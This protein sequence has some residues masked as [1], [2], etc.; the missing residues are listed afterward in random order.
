MLSR[1]MPGVIVAAA[2]ISERYGSEAAAAATLLAT[3][4]L[5]VAAQR[6]LAGDSGRRLARALGADDLSPRA[7]TRLRFLRRLIVAGIVVV[8]VALAAAQFTE[9]NRVANT[10]LASSAIAAAIVGFAARQ[11]LANAIA[12]LLLAVTQ[13][14]RIGDLV[15]FEEETGTVEELTLTSTWLRTS[16]DARIVI[17]NE[18]LA[19]GILRNDSIRSA[20]VAPEVSV[21]LAAEAD[22]ARALQLLSA[23]DGGCEARV[24]DVT[25]AGVRLA[26]TGPEVAPEQRPAREAALRAGALAALRLAGVPRAG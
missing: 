18:R 15:T 2:S 3:L 5:A 17:P 13:P 6:T 4:V 26:V 21:W 23:L 25:E 20:T 14:L 16:T 24:A 1:A 12:G 10:V 22:E 9:L 7:D 19:A 8:G 11:V